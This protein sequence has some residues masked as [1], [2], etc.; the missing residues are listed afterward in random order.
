MGKLP[1]VRGAG[2]VDLIR[3]SIEQVL[4]VSFPKSKAA[5]Y[6]PALN[7]AEQADKYAEVDLN[8]SVMHYAVFGSNRA[9]IGMALALVRYLKGVKA[10]QFYARGQLIVEQHR[11]E[12]VLSCFMESSAC[13]DPLAHCNKVVSDPFA[14]SDQ[15]GVSFDIGAPDSYL[16]P[17]AYLTRFGAVALHEKHP[18]SPVD[19]I[20]AKA[21]KLG[22]DWC[23]NFNP[24][25]FKKL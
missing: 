19:Q 25:D 22:C 17:C 14:R 11:I 15:G 5:G 10:T 13:N 18:A 24:G 6:A 21:V 3:D 8:G 12:E 23:P 20:Q 4:A 16:M 2:S 9:Q 1:A 7:L